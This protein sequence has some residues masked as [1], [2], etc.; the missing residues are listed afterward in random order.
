MLVGDPINS[1]ILHE[2]EKY[3]QHQKKN[4]AIQ[5]HLE[6]KLYSHKKNFGKSQI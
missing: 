4:R 5:I 1:F 3:L 2:L 6:K